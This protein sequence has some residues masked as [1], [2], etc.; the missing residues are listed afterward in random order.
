LIAV[1]GLEVAGEIEVKIESNDYRKLSS[2]QQ[3][4]ET[5]QNNQ[6]GKVPLQIVHFLLVFEVPQFPP[7]PTVFRSTNLQIFPLALR[8]LLPSRNHKS[9]L[10]ESPQLASNSPLHLLESNNSTNFPLQ[11]PD[12]PAPTMPHKKHTEISSFQKPRFALQQKPKKTF[13][14][15]KFFHRKTSPT[16]TIT[17]KRTI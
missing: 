10:S 5:A 4:Q 2:R 7:P 12:D 1:D 15:A 9:S 6:E 17:L 11:S 16:V 14:S 3:S 13:H 8:F